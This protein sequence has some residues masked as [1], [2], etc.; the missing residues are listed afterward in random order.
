MLGVLGG[1]RVTLDPQ[2]LELEFWKMSYMQV[3]DLNLSSL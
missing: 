1:L 3:L 2:E